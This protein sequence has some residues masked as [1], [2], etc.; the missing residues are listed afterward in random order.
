VGATQVSVNTMG[1][2]L[3]TVDAHLGALAVIAEALGLR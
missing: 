1:S 3:P 2:G